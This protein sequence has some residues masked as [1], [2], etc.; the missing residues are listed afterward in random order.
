M[1]FMSVGSEKFHS[2]NMPTLLPA[3]WKMKGTSTDMFLDLCAARDSTW[4]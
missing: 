4:F 2:H 1:C 3:Y